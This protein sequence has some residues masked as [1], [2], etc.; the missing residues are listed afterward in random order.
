MVGAR[1]GVLSQNQIR[2]LLWAVLI[3][4][5]AGAAAV[6]FRYAAVHLPQII[7]RADDGL[8]RAVAVSPTWIRLVIPTAGALLAGLVLMFG[9]RWSGP[10]HGWDILEAVVLRDGVLNLRPALIKSC[11]SL[12]TVASAGAI[13]RE[14]PMVLLAGTV[15]SHIGRFFRVPT[16]NLRVLVGC[17][18]AA[19]IACAY[20]TPIGAALF[21][22]E[23]IMGN[24]AIEVFAPL[25]FASVVATLI[26][27][28]VF[29]SLPVFRVPEFSMVSGWEMLPFALLGILGGLTAALFLHALRFSSAVFRRSGMPRPIAMSLVGFGLGFL[30]LWFPELAG[31]GREAI[32]DLFLGDWSP[33][34][35]LILMGL[36]LIMTPA[37]VGS[38][39]VGGV[40]TPTLFLGAALGDALGMLIHLLSPTLTAAPKAYALVGMGSLLAGTT[41]APL[42]AVLMLFEMTLDYRLVLPILLASAASSLVARSVARESVYTEAL[43]RKRGGAYAEGGEA[44]IMRKLA[45]RDV[46]RAEQTTIPLD[47]PL[48]QILDRFIATRRNHLYVV[49]AAGHF[50]GVVDLH[51]VHRAFRESENPAG[52]LAGELADAHFSTAFPMEKLDQVVERFWQQECERLPVLEDDESRKLLGTVSQR[53]I[54]SVCSMEA[55]HQQSLLAR[56]ETAGEKHPSTTIE[57]P[58]DHEVDDVPV[59]ASVVGLTLAEARFRERYGVSVLLI[60]RSNNMGQETRLIPEANTRFE[61]LDRLVVFGS[62]ENLDVLRKELA[63]ISHQVS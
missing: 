61:S 60:R 43:R 35:V 31:N 24:F 17:G 25:V 9:S 28:A 16:R 30:I 3:G 6:A 21:T 27:Q 32:R 39:A 45:V 51:E 62:R 50:K 8:V 7:W 33:I 47:L 20:N 42:T 11:S 34:Y 2:L 46:M 22:M 59:P 37:T 26:S 12:I 4:T 48:P 49:D 58:A 36:R 55:L 13:G 54:L 56:F 29:G 63:R 23:I 38:G 19:G 14:G 44:A 18:V 5:V 41:H 52:I 57:L 40:F 15:S 53:D 10:T 1:F